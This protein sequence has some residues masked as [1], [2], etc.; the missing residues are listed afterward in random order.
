M[1]IR[2]RGLV[3]DFL[4]CFLH[5]LTRLL[6]AIFPIHIPILKLNGLSS[7]VKTVFAIKYRHHK[8]YHWLRGQVL[9][10]IN[11]AYVGINKLLLSKR[12]VMSDH[13]A[14]GEENVVW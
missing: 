12:L 5:V 14:K 10:L 4:D 3:G 8:E 6:R 1:I 13:G 2:N 7:F 9:H 11:Q